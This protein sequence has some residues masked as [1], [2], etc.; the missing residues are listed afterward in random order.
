MEDI[1]AVSTVTISGQGHSASI[2]P[3]ASS[4]GKSAGG[5]R[6][7]KRA[8]LSVAAIMGGGASDP[9]ATVFSLKAFGSVAPEKGLVASSYGKLASFAVLQH[10]SFTSG[11]YAVCAKTNNFAILQVSYYCVII[12]Q[13]PL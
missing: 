10:P 4:S 13:F 5:L 6:L 8:S 9:L 12:L 7:G 2:A 1:H 11:C 3:Q